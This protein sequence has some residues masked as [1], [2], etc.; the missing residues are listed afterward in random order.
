MPNRCK[1]CGPNGTITTINNGGITVGPED[2][3]VIKIVANPT[4]IANPLEIEI[5]PLKVRQAGGEISAVKVQTQQG[6]VGIFN[7]S[8]NS[9]T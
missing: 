6:Y 8:P 5:F 9:N 3:I 1:R 4:V 2:N 7:D